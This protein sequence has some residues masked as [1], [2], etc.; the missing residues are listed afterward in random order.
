MSYSILVLDTETTSLDP[1]TGDII[2][3]SIYR[4]S[5]NKQKT[6]CIKPENIEGISKE[7]LAVNKHKLE[8]ILWLTEEGKTRYRPVS[9][10]LPEIENWLADDG[11][12]AADRIMAGHN[13][14]F[15]KN[16]LLALWE[17]NDCMDSF[18]FSRFNEIDTKSLVLFDEWIHGEYSQIHNLGACIKKYGLE[19]RKAH[20]ASEDT[21]M[22]KDLLLKLKERLTK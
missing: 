20:L 13:I 11:S 2:E 15:D 7:A 12:K 9:E 16:F 1:K 3:L 4:I 14:N 18:P 8:D 19:K 21:V 5:D 10:V 22:A 6:W 17:K